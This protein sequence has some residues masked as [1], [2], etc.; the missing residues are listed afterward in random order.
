M[1]MGRG[2]DEHGRTPSLAMQIDLT[3]LGYHMIYEGMDRFGCEISSVMAG[4]CRKQGFS[5]TLL[6]RFSTIPFILSEV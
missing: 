6:E 3:C 2:D 1:V 4:G 5:Y